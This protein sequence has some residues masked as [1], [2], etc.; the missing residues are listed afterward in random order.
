M[1]TLR[2]FKEGSLRFCLNLSREFSG[3]DVTNPEKGTSLEDPSVKIAHH[4]GNEAN[5]EK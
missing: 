1:S 3:R 4:P 2:H 5:A